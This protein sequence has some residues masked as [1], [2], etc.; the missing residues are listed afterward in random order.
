MLVCY[1]IALI[2]LLVRCQHRY[3]CGFSTQLI[4]PGAVTR[5]C[6]VVSPDKF[7]LTGVFSDLTMKWY[8]TKH[9]GFPAI[10]TKSNI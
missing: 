10:P 1:V 9:S 3:T 2:N 6:F 5:L 4:I 7:K 8:A